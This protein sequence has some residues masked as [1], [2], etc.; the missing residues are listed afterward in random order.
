MRGNGPSGTFG[1]GGSGGGGDLTGAQLN[2]SWDTGTGN[3]T[4]VLLDQSADLPWD[5]DNS[6]LDTDLMSIGAT[7]GLGFPATMTNCNAVLNNGGVDP[8]WVGITGM[9]LP[10]VGQSWRIRFYLRVSVSNAFNGSSFNNHHPIEN[11]DPGSPGA[12]NGFEFKFGWNTDGTFPCA[13]DTPVDR[14]LVTGVTLNKFVPYRFELNFLKTATDT[15]TITAGI[16]DDE[17]VQVADSS[18]FI[19]QLTNNG[20]LSED[21]IGIS[22]PDAAFEHL[23]LGINGGPSASGQSNYYGGVVV[24]VRTGTVEIGPHSAN[25]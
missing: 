22:I 8:S 7:T 13:F 11:N 18:D 9:T 14:W 16:W 24:C 1:E 6:G 21:G 5:N 25:G 23:R 17:D 20:P 10:S 4:A 19:G 2:S 15:Y 12:G 3:S